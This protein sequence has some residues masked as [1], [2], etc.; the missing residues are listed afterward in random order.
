M[1]F[2]CN[3]ILE[4][5]HYEGLKDIPREY[6]ILTLIHLKCVLTTGDETE[7]SVNQGFQYPDCLG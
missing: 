3:E 4:F 2:F 7:F 1:L 6:Q 5:G